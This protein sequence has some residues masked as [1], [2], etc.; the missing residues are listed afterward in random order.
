MNFYLIWPRAQRRLI[1]GNRL[2]EFL[3]ARQRISEVVESVFIDWID[4]QRLMIVLH[5]FVILSFVGQIE[6]EIVVGKIIVLCDLH[7]MTEKRFA[8][9]PEGQLTRSE[10]SAGEQAHSGA[11]APGSKLQARGK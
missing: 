5:R 8:I 10:H 6:T 1:I 4:F 7:G 11:E 2:L 9:S 3:F